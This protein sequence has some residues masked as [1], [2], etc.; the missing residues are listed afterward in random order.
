M[1]LEDTALLIPIDQVM[2]V[3]ELYPRLRE[4]DATI[5]RY[6][7][8]LDLLPP[9]TVA[10]ERVLVDGFHRW[11]A[12]RREGAAEIPAIDLGNLTDVEILKESIR[13]NARHGQQLD[14]KDKRRMADQLYRQ[15]I[16]D[17]TELAELLSITPKTLKE[18]L[19]DARRDEKEAQRAKAWDQWL[20][21][22]SERHIADRI[23]VAP[24]TVGTW[25]APKIQWIGKLRTRISPAFRCLVISRWRR[26][27]LFRPHA[28]AGCRKLVVGIYR[29]R[30][31]RVRPICRKR[32]D[33][34]HRESDGTA[35]VG[36]RHQ[37]E[38]S[39]SADP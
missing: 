15:G 36:E 25:I 11:Q 26:R 39:E 37:P 3:K 12:F 29:A 2:F 22:Y 7:A 19:R 24:N 17:N 32:D 9:I 18:Y 35:C 8:S 23:G 33:Y 28:P 20:D 27:Q 34:R 6:R 5:E 31:N 38:H 14:T 30:R 13:R 4:D 21:C 16:R 1:A 10:R